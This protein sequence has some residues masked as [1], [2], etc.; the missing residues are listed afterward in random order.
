MNSNKLT[1]RSLIR[2][3][4]LLA[5]GAVVTR[6]TGTAGAAIDLDKVETVATQGADQPVG[7]PVVLRQMVAR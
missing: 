5:A 4:S 3:T 6:L 2:N 7:E 1:R